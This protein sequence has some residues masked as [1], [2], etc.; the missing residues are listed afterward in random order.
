VVLDGINNVAHTSNYGTKHGQH[1][2]AIEYDQ[3]GK[4][5]IRILRNRDAKDKSQDT[6]NN[7]TDKRS[8]HAKSYLTAS[9]MR[10][11]GTINFSNSF[12][13]A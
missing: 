9:S 10:L 13:H 7:G 2:R 6:E 8:N 12:C 11:Y 4:C 1:R 5:L 3:Q